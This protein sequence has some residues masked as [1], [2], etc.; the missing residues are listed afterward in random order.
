MSIGEISTGTYGF[1]ISPFII[2]SLGNNLGLGEEDVVEEVAVSLQE[3][4]PINKMKPS[5]YFMAKKYSFS[6]MQPKAWCAYI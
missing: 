5:K 2:E 3:I 4:T 6:S 1:A